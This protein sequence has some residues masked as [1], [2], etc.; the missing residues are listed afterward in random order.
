MTNNQ[1]DVY[2]FIY[3]SKQ[4]NHLNNTLMN[5]TI[6][7]LVL[8]FL[9]NIFNNAFAFKG[10]VKNGLTQ[11]KLIGVNVSVINTDI[12]AITNK[13]GI[14]ELKIIPP[15]DTL[16]ISHIGYSSLNTK[17]TSSHSDFQTFLLF[18]E[19][20]GLDTVRVSASSELKLQ[21][22]GMKLSTRNVIKASP[23]SRDVFRIVH[24]LPGISNNN[25]GEARYNVHGGSY[26][27]NLV[28]LNNSTMHS[29]YH[30]R[31]LNHTTIGIF[32]LELV[33]KI[34]FTSGGF[35]P[36]Y[37]DALSSVLDIHYR[38]GNREKIKGK[39]E[40]NV[41]NFNMLLE[42]PIPGKKGSWILGARKSY[43][44]SIMEKVSKQIDWYK[45]IGYYDIQGQFDY[46]ITSNHHFRAQFIYSKDRV[47]LSLQESYIPNKIND[48]VIS[49]YHWNSTGYSNYS[50]QILTLNLNSVIS[51]KFSNIFNISYHLD[52][53]DVYDETNI[54]ETGNLQDLNEPDYFYEYRNTS[55]LL[56]NLKI[57]NI[58]FK[59]N[60]K[61]LLTHNWAIEGGTFYRIIQYKSKDLLYSPEVIRTNI[62]DFPDTTVI[63]T[64]N[65]LHRQNT[66]EFKTLTFKTGVFINNAFRLSENLKMNIGS[67][68]GYF[69]MNKSV[70]LSPRIS[71]VYE[72]PG[73]LKLKFAWGTYYQTPYYKQ[74]RYKY[75]TKEN[76]ENQQA[77]HYIFGLSKH[78]KKNITFRLEYYNKQYQNLIP[79]TR[80]NMG[81]LSYNTQLDN[82]VGYAKGIDFHF[83]YDVSPFYIWI[84][85]G[86]LVSREKTD[87]KGEKYYPRFTDQR[88]TLSSTFSVKLGNHWDFGLKTTYGSGYAY[89]PYHEV[90]DDLF[91]IY[92]WERGSKNESHYPNYL[93]MDFQIIKR[94]NIKN[95]QLDISLDI[96][97]ILNIENILSYSYSYT[98]NGD[99]YREAIILAPLFPS[100]R[101]SYAF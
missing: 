42:G 97:N 87:E 70:T 72:T 99:P 41:L 34:Y 79:V 16:L 95:N 47:N 25:S 6:R 51:E 67:R 53:S 26:D 73:E 11:E 86:Y 94:F 38:E 40:I 46:D 85:Y 33:E 93:R 66:N 37:G 61:Y 5:K 52:N 21:N 77:T 48:G 90:Y 76:T 64:Q 96:I 82:V 75:P 10:Q 83:H 7:L 43:F 92:T 89:T 74:F 12:G 91:N 29:P 14:F 8:I 71:F 44:G 59:Q 3:L 27:E 50:N 63:S 54:T 13:D 88:H 15:N 17:I 4:N 49:D 23:V 98:K 68:L 100:I 32:N 81:R 1:V 19:S 58:D 80:L 57:Q 22:S 62:L 56:E 60:S 20:Y 36:K 9:F 69:D 31:Q 78:F 101:F 18:P 30:M 2:L 35:G 65:S 45:Y 84:S 39:A 24:A 28:V 55:E